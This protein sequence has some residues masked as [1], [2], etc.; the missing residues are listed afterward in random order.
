M[1]DVTGIYVQGHMPIMRNV[2]I[3]V[4]VMTMLI[5]DRSQAV[6]NFFR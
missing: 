3:P 4:L 5:V 2:C 1:S 6:S